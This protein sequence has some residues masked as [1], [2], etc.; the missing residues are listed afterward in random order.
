MVVRSTSLRARLG[1][2]ALVAGY[3]F[4]DL[5]AGAPNSP[6]TPVLPRGVGPPRWSV[7]GADW[8]GLDRLS[9]TGLTIVSLL[10]LAALVLALGVVFLEAWRGRVRLGAVL[11]AVGVSLALAVAAPV[12]L[13]RDVYSYAVYGRIFTLHGANPYLVPP[14]AF[15]FDPFV[16]VASREWIHAP[17]VYGP[18]FT[19]LSASVAW[20]WGGSVAGTLLAFKVIAA[21]SVGVA[22]LLAART[23]ETIRPG[24]QA[25]AATAIGLNPVIVVHT[26]GGGHNDALL[27]LCIA[28]ALMLAVRS[29]SSAD[30]RPSNGH[31]T[32]PAFLGATTLLTL[33]VL[34]KSVALPILLLWLWHVVRRTSTDRRNIAVV[35]HGLLV[36]A[37][38]GAGFGPFAAGG[39]TFRALLSVASRQGWASGPGLVVR[40]ARAFGRAVGGGSTGVALD[41]LVSVAFAALFLALF[42]RILTRPVAS[43]QPDAW[44]RSMLLF[45]LAAPYFL[46]WYAAWFLPLVVFMED[47]TLMVIGMSAAGL[48]ALTGVPAEPGT[49]PHVWQAMM[50]GVHYGAAPLMLGMLGVAVRRTLA[51]AGRETA[52]RPCLERPR[53]TSSP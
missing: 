47:A 41:T 3:G 26:V 38:A 48:L 16:Q 10:I 4:L 22:S 24:K 21:A 36:V 29:Q 18:A 5:V 19:L 13:S 44:G 23:A 39:R 46:P 7:R 12:L 52:P 8:L 17:S 6:L 30:H 37:L 25:A 45:A 20:I 40:G 35:T 14:S 53:T 50:L 27:A 32:G 11:A 43:D 2:V 51:G 28:G 33:A 9:R 1:L 34:V 42:W 49:A 31:S 15:P